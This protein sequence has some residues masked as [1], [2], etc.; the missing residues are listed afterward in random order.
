[1]GEQLLCLPFGRNEGR[2]CVEN[3]GVVLLRRVWSSKLR[4]EYRVKSS[5]QD[6][7]QICRVALCPGPE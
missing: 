6:E 4:V 5:W 7:L 2:V 1:M 3:V